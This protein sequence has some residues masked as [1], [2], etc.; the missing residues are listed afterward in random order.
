MRKKTWYCENLTLYTA[1]CKSVIKGMT[2]ESMATR[3]TIDSFSI[4]E[5]LYRILVE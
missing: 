4:N 5:N 1:L 3:R 2:T